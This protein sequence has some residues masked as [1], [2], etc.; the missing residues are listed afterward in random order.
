MSPPGLR[1]TNP[2][3]VAI[4]LV[5]LGVA[6]AVACSSPGEEVG[7]GSGAAPSAPAA[8]DPA[9]PEGEAPTSAPTPEA[10]EAAPEAPEAP[11]LAATDTADTAAL[12]A[13][14]DYLVNVLMGCNDCH[15]PMG[16]QGP[17]M[18]R[19]L[20]GIDC[21]V[22][23]APPLDN[24]QG[25]ASTPNLTGDAT[26]LAN[27]SDDELRAMLTQGLRP[28][29]TA[30][31]PFMPYEFYAHL[32]A[33]DVDA[34]IAYLRT[35]PPVEHRVAASEPPFTAPPAPL[36]PVP[37]D[38]VPAPDPAHPDFEAATRGRYLAV[39]TG[40]CMS[41]H[42]PTLDPTSPI[43]D[44]SRSFAG[45]R[46]FPTAWFGMPAPPWPESIS[47]PNLTQHE[48]G[49]A[50]WTRDDIVRAMRDGVE[51]SGSR[52]C[53]P[54]GSGPMGPFARLTEQDLNDI[55]TYLLTLPGVES[56]VAECDPPAGPPPGH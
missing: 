37:M 23:I 20:A 3:V 46:T 35:V 1:R 51:P 18:T 44:W 4:G 38:L 49:L 14:G 21:W 17:D 50:A 47:T 25:C 42:T 27:R 28:D 39:N 31:I 56:A 29:G 53:P 15:T 19:Y 43:H 7:A 22:D 9:A 48:T 24:G 13:R 33:A 34:I 45:G 54:M 41:C 30:L 2:T 16:P 8:P 36:P 6:I 52:I 55:A 40:A 11:A 26:G 32:E 10:T 5:A 12:V